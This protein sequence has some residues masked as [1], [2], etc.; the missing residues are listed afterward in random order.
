MRG[1]EAFRPFYD[2]ARVQWPILPADAA[3]L[4]V[5]TPNG[6]ECKGVVNG[7]L[8][9]WIDPA[10]YITDIIAFHEIGHGIEAMLAARGISNDQVRTRLW[11]FRQWA[12]TW[13]QQDAYARSLP[14]GMQQ[15]QNLPVEIVAETWRCGHMGP[16][17]EE[18]TV[19]LGPLDHATQRA[20]YKS[21]EQEALGVAQVDYPGAIWKGSPNYWVGR[22][23]GPPQYIVE[24]W[25]VASA[26]STIATF[27]SATSKVS[28][29]YMV[30]RDGTVYQF[31]REANTAWHDGYDPDGY[32]PLPGWNHI[33]IGIE[34]EHE[35]G[36]D[37]PEVQM[38][39]S[40]ALHRS[41]EARTGIPLV[42]DHCLGHNETGYATSCPGDLPI[43]HIIG[44]DGMVADPEV[45]SLLRE[46]AT[47]TKNTFDK[48][49]ALGIGI[50]IWED[51]ASGG[52][53]VM[54]GGPKPGIEP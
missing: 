6:A 16:P 44:G 36:Q 37:W 15:W 49:N 47:N 38:R 5:T 3:I 31:V 9:F 29:H 24:H 14:S 35:P 40:D 33:S 42:R 19:Y 46:I 22:D 27:Q 30:A 32:G 7:V 52:R 8:T 12:G 43:D 20:F 26:S 41:I 23:F 34:H 39:S 45:L 28:A 48:V 25:T 2:A 13:Q 1:A 11:S 4:S 53:D 10:Y 50:P 21:L 18:R 17:S 51:R 54:T